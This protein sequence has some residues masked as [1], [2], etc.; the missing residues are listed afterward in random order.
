MKY[1]EMFYRARLHPHLGSRVT[2]GS[3]GYMSPPLI[4]G[5]GPPI[6]QET[7]PEGP[8]IHC[9]PREQALQMASAFPLKPD[10]PH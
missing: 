6:A 5:S 10:C 4:A 2:A 1:V 3:L 8:G 7:D 9:K